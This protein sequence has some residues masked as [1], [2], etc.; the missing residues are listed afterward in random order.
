MSDQPH[1]YARDRHVQRASPMSIGLAW[2]LVMIPLAWGLLS[3]LSTATLL[4]H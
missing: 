3:T 1:T 2:A 4:F